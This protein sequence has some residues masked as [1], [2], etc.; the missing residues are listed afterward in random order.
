[1]P[2]MNLSIER[3]EKWKSYRKF[4]LS[5]CVKP[6]AELQYELFTI[7]VNGA[8]LSVSQRV[9]YD[10]TVDEVASKTVL[11]SSRPGPAMMEEPALYKAKIIVKAPY[12][13]VK[14]W[15]RDGNGIEKEGNIIN[16]L[17]NKVHEAAIIEKGE[18]A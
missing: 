5:W 6:L 12:S 9:H 17:C 10:G 7:L 1:M 2:K 15:G 4:W 8:T 16:I 3:I 11:R 13:D 14:L 18:I